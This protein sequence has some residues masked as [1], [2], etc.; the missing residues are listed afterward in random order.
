MHVRERERER[1]QGIGSRGCGGLA[2]LKPDRLLQLS[3]DT[4]KSVVWYKGGSLLE[5]HSDS[6]LLK[7][8]NLLNETHLHYGI[9]LFS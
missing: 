4:R 9:N 2:N 8:F 6:F 5:E 7:A 3:G 1:D